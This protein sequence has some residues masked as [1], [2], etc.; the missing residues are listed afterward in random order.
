MFS[1]LIHYLDG[2]LLVIPVVLFCGT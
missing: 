1:V 2:K